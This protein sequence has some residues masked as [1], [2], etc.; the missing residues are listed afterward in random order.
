MIIG[1]LFGLLGSVLPELIKLYKDK[2]DRNFEMDML[3]LQ[4]QYKKELAQL[5]IDEVRA[6]ADIEVDKQVYEF[7]KPEIKPTGFYTVDLLQG[8]G[9]FL[10][11]LIRPV[12]TLSAM[13]LWLYG[14]AIGHSFSNWEQEVLTCIFVFWF[15]NR[16]FIRSKGRNN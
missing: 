1:A 4:I 11:T 9:T 7:A 16:A 6:L 14:L 3:R 13:G 10:N 5:R 15:G 12:I 2:Q 8:I